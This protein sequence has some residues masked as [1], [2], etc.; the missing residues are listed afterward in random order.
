MLALFSDDFVQSLKKHATLKSTVRKKV[1]MILTDSFGLGEPLK[2][3]F[4]GYYSASVKIN[5]LIIYLYCAVCRQRG[6][7][8][9][10]RCHDC[11]RCVHKT[12]KFVQLG[13]HDQA[14]GKR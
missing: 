9:I 8:V 1:D 3:N 11:S 13:P 4:R 14:Y 2:G 5:F 10:V 12:I 7:D 6:D